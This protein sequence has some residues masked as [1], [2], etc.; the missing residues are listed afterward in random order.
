MLATVINSLI[1]RE[2]LTEIGADCVLL[3]AFEIPHMMQS[4]ET[5]TALRH[6]RE[7]RVVVCCGGTGNPFVTTDSAATLRGVQTEV[8]AI[9]KLTN[10]SG[11][12]DRDPRKYSDAVHQK[13][14]DY[15]YCIKRQVQVMDMD[16]FNHC[17]R[18]SMPIHVAS[19]RE[20]D[21]IIRIANGGEIGTRIGKI[22]D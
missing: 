20:P 10:V 15:D 8:D 21:V 14:V 3:S 16:S 13:Q 22:G 6:L 11:V 19:Y 12:Y 7:G 5:H 18:V 2:K 9:I 4:F 1:I 17:K